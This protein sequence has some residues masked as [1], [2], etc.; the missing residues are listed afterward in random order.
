MVLGSLRECAPR[1][2]CVCVCVCVDFATPM[3]GEDEG[4]EKDLRRLV[5]PKGVGGFFISI[6]VLDELF[7]FL[8]YLYL[9][10]GEFYMCLF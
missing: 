6:F 2:V 8:D 1:C 5:T 4:E 7:A 3:G 9:L 10:L